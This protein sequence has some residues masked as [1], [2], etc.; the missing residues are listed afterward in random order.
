MTIDSD[1]PDR[2]LIDI[3]DFARYG[4]NIFVVKP[5]RFPVL[6]THLFYPGDYRTKENILNERVKSEK[7]M[8][9][10]LKKK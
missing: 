10:P 7:A 1:P 8:K 3:T 5:M 2:S 9:N 6:P 4:F